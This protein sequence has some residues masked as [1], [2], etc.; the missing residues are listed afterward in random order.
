MIT[1]MNRLSIFV[2][3]EKK[4]DLFVIS[5]PVKITDK[6]IDKIHKIIKA[7]RIPDYYG[8]RVGIQGGGCGRMS[9]NMLGFDTKK[10][11]DIEYTVHDIRLLVDKR[12]VIFLAGITIEYFQDDREQGFI[13]QHDR[14]ES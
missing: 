6:A 7:K 4:Y 9:S 13:F 11:H 1:K 5:N 3:P 10:E 2:N 8:L 12:Q 14:D